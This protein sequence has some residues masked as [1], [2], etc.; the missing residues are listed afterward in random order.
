[1]Q[2]DNDNWR[3]RA[4]AKYQRLRRQCA[5]ERL[6]TQKARPGQLTESEIPMRLSHYGVWLSPFTAEDYIF[7]DL[8][9]DTSTDG[10]SV[11][12]FT[13]E[14]GRRIY[15]ATIADGV[16]KH[17]GDIV[18]WHVEFYDKPS[19]ANREI[20]RIASEIAKVAA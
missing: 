12:R 16:N 9:H 6:M 7:Y 5:A 17:T 4:E 20:Y 3:E 13:S 2:H 11:F 19:S 15:A 18:S 14:D 8:R 10:M 1:M